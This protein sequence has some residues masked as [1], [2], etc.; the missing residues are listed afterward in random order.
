MAEL[1]A[2][3]APA[4]WQA[5]VERA[6]ELGLTPDDNRRQGRRGNSWVAA[7]NALEK[8]LAVLV[9][10]GLRGKIEGECRLADGRIERL[11]VAHWRAIRSAARRFYGPRQIVHVLD[12]YHDR[13]VDERLDSII[14]GDAGW[15]APPLILYGV[16]LR[17]V[18]AR[19][20]KEDKVPRRRGGG[21][22]A[23]SGA[24]DDDPLVDE[25]ERLVKDGEAASPTAAAWLVVKRAAGGGTLESKVKRLV[26]KLRR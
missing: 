17:L 10:V 6:A 16:D 5:W 20:I 8:A 11:G 12:L 2:Q 7:M 15:L 19:A 22:P 18:D 23:G 1:A 25:I 24:Y 9:D 13:I 21:R 14:P 4:E 3:L 26:A